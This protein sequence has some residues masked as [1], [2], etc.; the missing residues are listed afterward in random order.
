M[1]LVHSTRDVNMH[2]DTTSCNVAILLSRSSFHSDIC[3]P[4]I[5][6]AD[7]GVLTVNSKLLP[8]CNEPDRTMCTM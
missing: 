1:L 3:S 6:N 4:S 5:I 2:N 8:C 7:Y